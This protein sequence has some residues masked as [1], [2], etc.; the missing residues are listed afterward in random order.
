MAVARAPEAVHGPVMRRWIALAVV[1]LP[2][3]A[4]AQAVQPGAW[5]VTSTLSE[6]S[7]PGVPSFLQR[8]ARGHS[9]AEHKRLLAGQ[10][11]E[12]LLAPDPKARCRVDSQNVAGGRYAQ[13]LTCPQKRG[14]TVS[15]SRTGTY[16]ASGFVGTATVTGATAKGA[17]RIA[18]AQ[19]AARV[20]G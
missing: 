1:V 11:V 8:M 3:A 12:A 16:D 20:G 4:L 13:A 15:I 7:V 14:G 17:L 18:L 19:R 5:D 9:S 10:G 2:G 6:L